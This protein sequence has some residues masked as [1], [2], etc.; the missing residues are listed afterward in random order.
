MGENQSPCVM[1]ERETQNVDSS[2]QMTLPTAESS[3]PTSSLPML[4]VTFS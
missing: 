2:L 4:D 3:L 1:K